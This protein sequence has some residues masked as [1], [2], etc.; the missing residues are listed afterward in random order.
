M[1]RPNL[2]KTEKPEL[3]ERETTVG[4]PYAHLGPIAAK[5]IDQDG[6][7]RIRFIKEPRWIGYS[8]A[9]DVLADFEDLLSRP[10]M[11]RMPGRL[12]VGETNSG[13]TEILKRFRSR[14][15]GFVNP[16]GQG[17]TIPVLMV[18]A[19]PTPDE[20]RLYENILRRLFA[21]FRHSD[22]SAK[23]EALVMYHLMKTKTKVIIIDELQHLIA[24]PS[25]RHRQMLNAIK[26]LSNELQVSIIG[27][28]T[29][30]AFNAVQKDSQLENRLTPVVLSPWK[31]DEEFYRLLASFERILPLQE[32][33]ELAEEEMAFRLHNLMEG[34]IGE[35]ASL[36]V[37]AVTIAIRSGREK[38][39][40][41]ILNK[42]NWKPPSER[43]H[44]ADGLG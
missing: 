34:K 15:E 21:P 25:N 11:D 16:D 12:L 42:M 39:D 24:G 9:R 17:S 19:P 14:H 23:R 2:K 22:S 30:E 1:P 29:R 33:S 28:G 4:S 26:N 6:E 20:S 37:E 7:A 8:K 44:A 3:V 13:K 32:P 31:L 5:V 36:L 41:D 27:A 40:H 18:L 10:R 43:A 38:I 35:L